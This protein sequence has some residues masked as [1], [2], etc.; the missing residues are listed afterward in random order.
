MHICTPIA[1]RA[2]RLE[3]R[4]D[5]NDVPSI[6]L[7]MTPPLWYDIVAS[8]HHTFIRSHPCHL[9]FFCINKIT[10]IFNGQ[11]HSLITP[12]SKSLS[13]NKHVYSRSDCPKRRSHSVRRPQG[14]QLCSWNKHHPLQ[15]QRRAGWP[16]WD[17]KPKRLNHLFLCYNLLML[18]PF[19]SGDSFLSI[20]TRTNSRFKASSL[21]YKLLSVALQLAKQSSAVSLISLGKPRSLTLSAPTGC[22]SNQ[23]MA[24]GTE[25]IHAVD[26]S[27]YPSSEHQSRVECPR[28]IWV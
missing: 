3:H 24:N 10:L 17:P 18:A 23:P 7:Q 2:Q 9:F 8:S 14:Q 12:N 16:G 5:Y 4:L 28:W 25:F 27:K 26:D 1:I 15:P 11:H 6:L 19:T 21:V 22:M 20:R 13:S